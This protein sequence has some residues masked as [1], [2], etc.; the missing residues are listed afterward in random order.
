[1]KTALRSLGAIHAMA[2][3]TN[4]SP[5]LGKPMKDF[6]FA[7]QANMTGMSRTRTVEHIKMSPVTA[8]EHADIFDQDGN[9]A[10]LDAVHVS[11]WMDKESG[12][13]EPK[14]DGG[15]GDCFGPEY[16]CGIYLH[17]ELNEPF[18]IIKTSF[19]GSALSYRY[20]S[21]S[22]DMWTPVSR[23]I[24][25]INGPPRSMAPKPSMATG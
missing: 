17:K 9:P 2:F 22:S 13:L 10:N 4:L 18:L 1:M 5:A 15:K 8:K 14:Y 25:S 7:G 23:R 16:A 21:P 11:Q 12:R 6:I 24:P 19:G 20:R 3:L